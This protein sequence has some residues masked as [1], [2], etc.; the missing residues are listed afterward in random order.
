M[1]VIGTTVSFVGEATSSIGESAG[2]FLLSV[3]A[4]EVAGAVEEVAGADDDPW[5][6]FRRDGV[7]CGVEIVPNCVLFP[8]VEFGAKQGDWFGYQEIEA[9][10]LPLAGFFWLSA[11]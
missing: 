3:E 1:A 10:A 6:S 9:S 5:E 8:G 4:A 7:L 11:C 2:F